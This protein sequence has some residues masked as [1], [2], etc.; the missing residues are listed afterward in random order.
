MVSRQSASARQRCADG[1]ADHPDGLPAYWPTG[2]VRTPRSTVKPGDGTG[3]CVADRRDRRRDLVAARRKF[4]PRCQYV[5]ASPH[6]RSHERTRV[7]S[8]TQVRRR[9]SLA[10]LAVKVR[11]HRLK[12]GQSLVAHVK[13]RGPSCQ[14]LPRP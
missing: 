2:A 9:R 8:V 5:W 12:G 4:W 7:T 6:S 3:P 1:S 11:P 14:S 13:C 10:M